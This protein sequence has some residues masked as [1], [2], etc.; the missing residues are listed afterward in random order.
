MAGNQL[1]YPEARAAV[2]AANRGGRI[3]A[4]TL[5]RAVELIDELH[6]QLTVISLDRTLVRAAGELAER[7]GLRG[8][9]A[10]HLAAALRI[11]SPDLVL[12]TWDAALADAAHDAGCIVAPRHV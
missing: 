12:V 5:R 3:D 9:D 7:H 2:A 11:D 1:L 10:V 6:D 4:R 8:Y